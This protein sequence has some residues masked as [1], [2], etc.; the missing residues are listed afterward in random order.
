MQQL[1]FHPTSKHVGIF[2][3]IIAEVKLLGPPTNH[4]LWGQALGLVDHPIWLHLGS[5]ILIRDRPV[6]FIWAWN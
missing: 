4:N 6:F 2:V 3:Q 5:R 1:V